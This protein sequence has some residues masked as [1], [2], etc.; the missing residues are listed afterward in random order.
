[1]DVKMMKTNLSFCQKTQSWAE[2]RCHS[3]ESF[4]T[5]EVTQPVRQDLNSGDSELRPHDEAHRNEENGVS[6]SLAVHPW[7]INRLAKRPTRCLSDRGVLAHRAGNKSRGSGRAA[8]S[9]R[10]MAM[11]WVVSSHQIDGWHKSVSPMSLAD[12]ERE[13]GKKGSGRREVITS[14]S[15]SEITAWCITC[16]PCCVV[17]VRGA[18]T[19]GN[20]MKN[21]VSA[22]FVSH[23][24]LCS[25][26][27]AGV[28]RRTSVCK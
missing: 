17:C 1:M 12:G 6:A 16:V 2:M 8:P 25:H 14:T 3:L 24:P 27:Q 22:P 18:Q 28:S 7:Q 23:I 21:A 19:E 5:S 9:W 20:G 13:E 11:K 10:V 26:G 15:L 4:I